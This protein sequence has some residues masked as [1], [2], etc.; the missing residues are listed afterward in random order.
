MKFFSKIFLSLLFSVCAF[1][2]GF[3]VSVNSVA[4]ATVTTSSALM[5]AGDAKLNYIIIQNLGPSDIIIKPGSVQ[6]GSEGI[7]IPSGGNYEPIKGFIDP[8]YAKT[9]SGSATVKIVTGR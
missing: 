1:A 2:G 8:I 4:T 5:Y 6:S 3:A 9:A 7:T